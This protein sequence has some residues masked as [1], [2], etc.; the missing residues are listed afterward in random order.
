MELALELTVLHAL[1]VSLVVK[2]PHIASVF[3]F[4][5]RFQRKRKSQGNYQ[6]TASEGGLNRR[7]TPRA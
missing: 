5:F 3:I 4:G 2:L 6:G 7:V 1:T